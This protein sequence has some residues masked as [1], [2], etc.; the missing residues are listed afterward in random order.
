[1]FDIPPAAR[2]VTRWDIPLPIDEREWQIGLVVGPSGA[3]KSTLARHVWPDQMDTAAVWDERA[4]IDNFPPAMSIKDITALLC[5]V[6]LSSPPAWLRPRH[7]LSGGEG[8]RADVAWRLAQTPK[9]ATCVIDEWTS[10]VDR[11]VA[12]VAS[13]TAAKTVRRGGQRLVAVTCHYD[14]TDWLQPDWIVDVSA[15]DF[16]WRQV[17]P[18]PRLALTVHRISGRE[19]W[20]RFARHHYLSAELS[21]AA[22]CFGAFTDTGQCVAFASYLHFPHPK[23]RNLKM[24][25]RIVCLPDYQGL[26]IGAYMTAWLGQRLWDQGYRFRIMSAHPA[27]IHACAASRRWLDVSARRKSVAVGPNAQQRARGL[28]V[29]ALNTRSFEYTPPAQNVSEG[30]LDIATG[31]ACRA[32]AAPRRASADRRVPSGTSTPAPT[33]RGGR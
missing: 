28:N 3:G 15:A 16:T 2:R 9:G 8:F 4:L 25:H 17:Q 32:S 30:P 18:R 26:G 19:T 27:V 1:M 13:H 22:Q 12:K 7:T 23:T 14:V 31:P 10:T 21:A 24:A 6:G 20:P 11:Q 5:S 33:G 29:R